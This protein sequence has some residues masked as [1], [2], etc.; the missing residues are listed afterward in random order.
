M[1]KGASRMSVCLKCRERYM[2]DRLLYDC[3]REE[4]PNGEQDE[5]TVEQVREW[6]AMYD[7]VQ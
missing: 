4:K 2:C 3:P 5:L 7:K 6:E 1:E